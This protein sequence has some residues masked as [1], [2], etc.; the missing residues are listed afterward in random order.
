MFK[1]L[2]FKQYCREAGFTKV[3][4]KG[5]LRRFDAGDWDDLEAFWKDCY[6]AGMRRRGERQDK[7]SKWLSPAAYL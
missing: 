1:R 4:V 6:I 5:C 3:E 2:R 7:P